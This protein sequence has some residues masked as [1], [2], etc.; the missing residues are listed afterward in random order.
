MVQS[1]VNGRE[2]SNGQGTVSA[3]DDTNSPEALSR[4]NLQ[5]S[6]SPMEPNKDCTL[7]GEEDG[8]IA[9]RDD[10][11]A[12]HNEC[13]HWIVPGI[14]PASM[15]YKVFMKQKMSFGQLPFPSPIS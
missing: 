9:E 7:R 3:G 10:C 12:W 14:D 4:I 1:E 15:Y 8:Q 5:D 2:P 13:S 11:G 6:T